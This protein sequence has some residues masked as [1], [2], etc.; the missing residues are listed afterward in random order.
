L[1]KAAADTGL[2]LLQ[3]DIACLKQELE[4]EKQKV[5]LC[6]RKLRENLDFAN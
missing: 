3:K 1:L 4:V 2:N 5:N 6:S